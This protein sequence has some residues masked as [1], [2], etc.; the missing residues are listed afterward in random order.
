MKIISG[1]QTGVDRAAL[2]AALLK[3]LPIGG[4]VPWGFRAEDGAIPA[5]LRPFLTQL[6]TPDYEARTNR[7]VAAADA[8]LVLW[9][10]P[11]ISPGSRK[12][13]DFA[14]AIRKHVYVCKLQDSQEDGIRLWLANLKPAT[15]NIAGTRESKSPGVEKAALDF[16]LRLL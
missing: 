6:D 16:L 9:R 4:F 1:A 8:T 14:R 10:G 13:A 3:G 2:Y 11:H 5:D 15:L 12:T 7:N